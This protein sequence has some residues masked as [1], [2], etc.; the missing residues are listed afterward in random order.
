MV[1]LVAVASQGDD[2]G[3]M[4]QSVQKRSCSRRLVKHSPPVLEVQVARHDQ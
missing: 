1:Y 2:V 4:K 3:V